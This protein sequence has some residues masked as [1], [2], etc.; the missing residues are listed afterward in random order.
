MRDN[1]HVRILITAAAL[2]LALAGVSTASASRPSAGGTPTALVIRLKSHVRTS[3]N[4]DTPPKGDS[5]GDR[6]L[7][8]DDLINVVTQFGKRPGAIIGHDSGIITLSGPRTASIV[9]VAVLPDGR[10]S[11]KG[12]LSLSSTPGPPLTVTG[13]TGRYAQARGKVVIGSGNFPLNTYKITVP[14]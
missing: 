7:V 1:P 12:A 9:G 8:R 10:I 5:K 6:Y 14:V 3:F 4:D 2:G 13:G 11:F